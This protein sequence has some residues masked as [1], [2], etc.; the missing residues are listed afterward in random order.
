MMNDLR[1][2]E[3]NINQRS[4]NRNIKS[5]ICTELIKSVPHIIILVE[6]KKIWILKSN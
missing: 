5:F 1:I 2:V 4:K 6:Y 3:W